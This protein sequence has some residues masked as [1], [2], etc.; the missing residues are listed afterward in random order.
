MG[1]VQSTLRFWS[2][3]G[4]PLCDPVLLEGGTNSIALSADG[5]T[6]A[7]GGEDKA[8][9]FWTLHGEP[10]GP[11][12]HG[13]TAD[14][15][16]VNFGSDGLRLASA[17]M[18]GTVWVWSLIG[19]QPVKVL[20]AHPGG[21]TFAAFRAQMPTLLTGGADGIF[22]EWVLQPFEAQAAVDHSNFARFMS[23]GRFVT[24]SRDGSICTRERGG[25]TVGTESKV[26]AGAQVAFSKDARWVWSYLTYGSTI[27]L[28]E[29]GAPARVLKF[30]HPVLR[31]TA[32]SEHQRLIVSDGDRLCVYDWEGK[33]IASGTA[34]N[35][36]L[37]EVNDPRQLFAGVGYAGEASLWNFNGKCVA[38]PGKG[39][40]CRAITFSPDGGYWALGFDDGSVTVLRIPEQFD[41][42]P[43]APTADLSGAAREMPGHK[44]SVT[45]L[46]FSADGQR[47]ASAAADGTIRISDSSGNELTPLFFA[48]CTISSLAFSPDGKILASAGED[49][50]ARFWIADWQG[51]L[52]LGRKRLAATVRELARARASH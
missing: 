31:A 20:N 14:V 17:S 22:R 39:R 40:F 45:A 38:K 42:A 12:L 4:G 47:L 25:K 52:E 48:G 27:T 16:S 1:G 9:R 28:A 18:D 5:K 51:W 26:E 32:S 35:Q 41:S 44:K 2:R 36:P 46:A 6:I 29:I 50:L 15:R 10:V 43:N 11:P 30:D 13:H 33:L 3:N 8:I 21:T 34:Q 24:S 7:S 49:D 23:D 37:L 19:R